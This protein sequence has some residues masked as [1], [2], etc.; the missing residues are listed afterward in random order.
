MSLRLR[1]LIQ[2]LFVVLPVFTG[3]RFGF[4]Q[5]TLGGL[6]GVVTDA[7]GGILPG[8][9]VTVVGDETGLK[10][11]PEDGEQRVSTS[12]PTC[13]LGTY[14]LTVTHDGFQ[15]QMFPGIAVQGGPHRDGECDAGGG[16]GVGSR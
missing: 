10:R 9:D 6:T 12:S 8:T 7:Q 14:T 5:Q 1:T 16:R 11:E 15:T 4:A 2:V 13:R 3:A